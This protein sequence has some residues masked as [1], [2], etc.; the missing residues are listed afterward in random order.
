MGLSEKYRP[1]QLSD[2][3]QGLDHLA[4][5]VVAWE[6]QNN[7]LSGPTLFTAPYGGGKTTIARITAMRTTCLQ[8]GNHPFEPCLSC[9]ACRS[10]LRQ[11]ASRPYFAD[12]Y[13][14]SEI[15]CAKVSFDEV[16]R[17]VL[18]EAAS[19]RMWSEDSAF[20]LNVVILDEFGRLTIPQQKKF[21]KLLE[22][23][24]C[25]CILCC[26][27]EDDLDP[28]I[29]Q[30]C[31]IRPL[32]LPS[33]ELCVKHVCDMAVAEGGTA[34]QDAARW[35][36]QRCGNNPREIIKVLGDALT[37]GDGNLDLTSAESALKLRSG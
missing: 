18:S 29:R 1:K 33:A 36:S 32:G 13:G 9:N 21:L 11:Q 24:R 19:P 16:C 28:A 37:L 12:P 17:W 6:L 14:Y 23:S 10:I 20:N 34:N 5:R 30:R 22:V 7:K 3:W 26:A 25:L 27:D 2:L 31:S 4:I 15:D 8:P 35:L